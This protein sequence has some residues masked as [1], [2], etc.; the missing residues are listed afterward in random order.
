MFGTAFL[1]GLFG[2]AGGMILIGILLAVMPLPAAMALHAVTQMA[3]NGW[4]GLLWW[5]HIRLAPASGYILGCCLT[6]VVWSTIRY[7]PST[8]AAMFFLGVTPF[9]LRLLPPGLKPDAARLGHGVAYGGVCM[10]L[11]LLTGVAGPLIDSFFLGGALDRREIVATKAVCQLFGHAAK[12]LYFGGI[13][14]QAAAVD[15]PMM[16]VAIAASV[17][18]TTAARR[19]LEAMTEKQFRTWAVRIITSISGYYI[20]HGSYLLAAP[21]LGSWQ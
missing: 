16:L 17:L 12:L 21:V 9:A 13:V 10:T 19:F 14:E 1:S 11:L 3:S 6:L 4:R 5:R 20:L 15:G 8:P 18:G 7:V 2:M